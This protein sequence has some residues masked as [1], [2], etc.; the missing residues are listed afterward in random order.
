M[1]ISKCCQFI[2]LPSTCKSKHFQITNTKKKLFEFAR[3]LNAEKAQKMI[4]QAFH[5]YIF[6]NKK[7]ETKNQT[8]RYFYHRQSLYFNFSFVSRCY[9]GICFCFIYYFAP[10]VIKT[11]II[12]IRY[13]N[14]YADFMKNN[15]LQR[16]KKN[17][18]KRKFKYKI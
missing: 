11:S 2:L 12:L 10:V 1:L 8:S 3:M 5:Y 15:E 18:I 14:S 16:K 9:V 4:I 6:V 7:K 13:L 17:K